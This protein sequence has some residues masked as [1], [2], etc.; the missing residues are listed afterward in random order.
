M[1]KLGLQKCRNCHHFE[2]RW[3]KEKDG[4]VK[5][6]LYCGAFGHDIPNYDYSPEEHC[7]AFSWSS[8]AWTELAE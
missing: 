4:N 6:N 1:G 2:E 5:V 3:L 8:D 7:F